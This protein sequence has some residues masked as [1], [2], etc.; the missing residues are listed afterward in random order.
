M[1]L[2]GQPISDHK[3]GLVWENN[4]DTPITSTA[5]SKATDLSVSYLDFKYNDPLNPHHREGTILMADPDLLNPSVVRLVL[6][7][8]VVFSIINQIDEVTYPKG[9]YKIFDTGLDDLWITYN[10][11]DSAGSY[12]QGWDQNKQWFVFI[13]DERINNEETGKNTAQIIVSQSS[14]Y[15]QNTPIPGGGGYFSEKDTRLIGG[16]KSDNSR[17]IIRESVWD[18]AGKHHTVKAKKYMILDE[19]ATSSN[20]QH[21]YRPLRASD[22]EDGYDTGNLSGNIPISNGILNTNLN[23]DFL[24]GQHGT[25]YQNAG[26]LNAGTLPDA[27]LPGRLGEACK[28]ITNWDDVLTNGWYMGNSATNSPTTGWYLGEVLVHHAGWVTQTLH[29]FTGDSETDSKRYRRSRNNSIWGSWYRIYDTATEI[30]GMITSSVLSTGVKIPNLNADLLDGYNTSTSDTASTVVIR[31]SIGQIN[32]TSFN[33]T[34]KREAKENIIGF[35]ESA[36]SILSN[37]DIV[38]FNYKV[39]QEKELKIGF[40]ADDTHEYLASK[41]HDKMDMGNTMGLLIKAIQELEQEIIELK[42]PWWKKIF[43]RVV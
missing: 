21:V 13:C 29:G 4:P 2:E 18:I 9:Q 1:A 5:L 33:A 20:G 39:D 43:K 26:N 24:D 15:P 27:R 38:K 25:F 28:E 32:A 8:G 22:L 17:N 6:K 14:K 41:D 31:T 37:V 23:A 11:K 35:D 36:L 10:N 42:T 40:I 30:G 34:S 19:Y 7:R 12:L 16:F 3:P